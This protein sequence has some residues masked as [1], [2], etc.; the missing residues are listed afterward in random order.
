MDLEGYCYRFHGN[1]N[2]GGSCWGLEA[3]HVE[4]IGT[5]VRTLASHRSHFAAGAD[6]AVVVEQTGLA[7]LSHPQR[8]ERMLTEMVAGEQLNCAEGLGLA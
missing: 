3:T 5:A 1:S 7:V 4:G 6:A 2:P 8:E